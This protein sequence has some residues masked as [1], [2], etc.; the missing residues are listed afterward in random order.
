MAGSLIRLKMYKEG[1]SKLKA[2]AQSKLAKHRDKMK[3]K[4]ARV[5]V[6][7]TNDQGQDGKEQKLPFDSSFDF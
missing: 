5:L 3:A 6:I 1:I 2:N 7:K 4:Q